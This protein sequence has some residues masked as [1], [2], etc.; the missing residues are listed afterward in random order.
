MICKEAFMK[1]SDYSMN[2]SSS[3]TNKTVESESTFLKIWGGSSDPENQKKS[4]NNVLLDLSDEGKQLY[5]KSTLSYECAKTESLELS[6]EDVSSEEDLKQK[7]ICDFIYYLTGKRI[8]L[9]KLKIPDDKTST[10]NTLLNPQASV[11]AD[12]NLQSPQR[13]WWG[14][15]FNYNNSYFEGSKVSFS[16][17]GNIRTADGRDI[18]LEF[19]LNMSR[20]FYSSTN[21]SFKA[22]DALL[23]PLVINLGKT[24]ALLSGKKISFDIN[25]D[26]SK[27]DIFVPDSSSAFLVLDKNNNGS[28]DDGSELFGPQTGNG[29]NELSKYD[30]DSNG[31][32]D[33]NDPIY[34]DLQIWQH[35]DAGNSSL[36]A[37][38]K[39]GVG[40][41]YLGSAKTDFKYTDSQNNTQG[42]LRQ[43]GIFLR[44]DGSAGTIQHIDLAI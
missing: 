30:S 15:N 40:A 43:T 6:E 20:S 7:L 17:K 44:E 24:P 33:E 32:I 26:G 35:D 3:S 4:D 18:D 25:I 19:N 2:L 8:K 9:F 21:I 13:A 28:V 10:D 23:D 31:W 29:F 37:I 14:I 22:G 12:T 5:L 39:A 27:E 1:I 11:S 42:V 34:N 41:I 16:A 38:G 36:I